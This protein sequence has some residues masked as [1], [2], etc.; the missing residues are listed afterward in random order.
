MKTFAQIRRDIEKA[1]KK[2]AEL[3]NTQN[4]VIE[5]WANIADIKERVEQ[6]RAKA[7]EMCK[8]EQDIKDLGLTI[9]I[10]NSNAKI[11][12]FTECLPI[13][14]EILEKYSGKAYGEKTRSKIS[15]EMQAKTGCRLFIQQSNYSNDTKL[16]LYPLNLSGYNIECGTSGK[17][18]KEFLN[19]ENKIQVVPLEDVKLYY[20]SNEYVENVPKRIRELKK[21][22]E[23]AI[24]A[25]SELEKACG[26][27][28]RLAVGSIEH[29]YASKYIYNF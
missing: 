3:K 2:Q 12:L 24:Q 19:V 4:T 29:I 22:R 26:N 14:L 17:D 23:K 21:A 8:L 5:E 28:N 18:R 20:D 25:Q 10:L 15:D 13:A 11:A 27:F 1:Y 16:A 6:K 7:N 9:Q